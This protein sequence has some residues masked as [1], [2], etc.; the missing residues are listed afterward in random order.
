MARLVQG[1][2]VVDSGGCNGERGGGVVAVSGRRWCMVL[3]TFT[4]K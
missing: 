3:F 4:K 2:L 1:R